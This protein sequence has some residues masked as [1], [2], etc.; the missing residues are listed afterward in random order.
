MNQMNITGRVTDMIAK[1]ER[2]IEKKKSNLVYYIWGKG[3]YLFAKS[4]L[5]SPK[6]ATLKS[7]GRKALKYFTGNRIAEIVRSEELRKQYKF[8]KEALAGKYTYEEIA[9]FFQGIG[10][11]KVAI[12]TDFAEGKPT[13]VYGT[14]WKK[15]NMCYD[16][17][18]DSQKPYINVKN[19]ELKSIQE[20][21]TTNPD[22]S[23][24]GTKGTSN[25]FDFTEIEQ[26]WNK[27]EKTE[28]L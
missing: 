6:D 7:K 19:Q 20:L 25:G 9:A 27:G 8:N 2:I 11:S 24:G 23:R 26:E 28:K 12:I 14:D 17:G 1:E 16:N 22:Q 15:Y 21:N 13:W 3:Y 5:A 4:L 10:D 18:N